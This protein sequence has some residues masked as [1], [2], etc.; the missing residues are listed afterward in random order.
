MLTSSLGLRKGPLSAFSKLLCSGRRLSVRQKQ[1]YDMTHTGH[2]N[3]HRQW[4]AKIGP[5]QHSVHH[6]RHRAGHVHGQ[7]LRDGQVGKLTTS[8]LGV[9]AEPEDIY[10][11]ALGVVSRVV[12]EL[13][14]EAQPPRRGQRITVICLDNLLETGPVRTSP[15]DT[16]MD[17]SVESSP[18][19]CR[20]IVIRNRRGLRRD[21]V[22]GRGS[23]DGSDD[24]G[25]EEPTQ[26][27]SKKGRASARKTIHG[28]SPPKQ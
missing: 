14:V 1:P 16:E 8:E 26:F 21:D 19:I 11:T 20:S 25:A 10:R 23:P 28:I 3:N 22:I 17:A 6:T 4:R 18:V 5:A 9:Q 7:R 13:I 27:V 24:E 2:R 15:S 12:D